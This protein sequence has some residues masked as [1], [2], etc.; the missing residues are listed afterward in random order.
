MLKN[1]DIKKQ[2]TRER[3]R[4]SSRKGLLLVNF[5]QVER[6]WL[7]HLFSIIMPFEGE[8]QRTFAK[9]TC[10]QNHDHSHR[11]HKHE[12]IHMILLWYFKCIFFENRFPAKAAAQR[13][14]FFLYKL[15]LWCYYN[16]YFYSLII[17][18]RHKNISWFLTE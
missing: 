7:L 13:Q 5:K 10:E 18:F 3:E 1:T 12:H 17:V 15:S 4:K 9:L 14:R 6:A 2:R 8:Q 11:H 16:H